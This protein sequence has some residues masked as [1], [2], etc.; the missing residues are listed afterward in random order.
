MVKRSR[1]STQADEE[2]WDPTSSRPKALNKTA[3]PTLKDLSD[4]DSSQ[5]TKRSATPAPRKGGRTRVACDQCSKRRS[6]CSLEGPACEGCVERGDPEGCSYQSL[7]W[8]QN[9]EDLPSRQL[10][11]KLDALEALLRALPK[12]ACPV[13]SP[14][15][16]SPIQLPIPL[17]L[18]SPPSEFATNSVSA[19]LSSCR[20]SLARSLF[21][22]GNLSNMH[23]PEGVNLANLDFELRQIDNNHLL[24]TAR[25]PPVTPTPL[26]SPPQAHLAI[27]FF[28]S[29]V[30]PTFRL[31]YEPIFF[32][33]CQEFWASGMVPSPTWLSLYLAVCASGFKVVLG[34]KEA[35]NQS[36]MME[37][38]VAQFAEKCWS[39]SRDIL[40]GEGFPLSNSL[41]SIQVALTLA[42]STLYGDSSN[43]ARTS[44]LVRLAANAALD[45]GLDVDP[46][47][48]PASATPLEVEMRRRTFW[49]LYTCEAMLELITGTTPSTFAS[50]NPSARRPL[51]L[52]N[53]CYLASGNLSPIGVEATTR[54][55][56]S[57]P[58]SA[59]ITVA[60]LSIRVSRLLT[61]RGTD[62]ETEV[63]QL[64][65]EMDS[66]DGAFHSSQVAET[67]FRATFV[68]LSQA[69]TELNLSNR[70]RDA[71]AARHLDTLLRSAVS[72]TS[73]LSPDLLFF[74]TSLS[75]STALRSC[76]VLYDGQIAFERDR[77][78][79]RNFGIALHSSFRA[80]CLRLPVSRCSSILAHVMAQSRRSSLEATPSLIGSSL[81]T[82]SSENTFPSP[83]MSISVN[84][85]EATFRQPVP[86][87]LSND[88][89]TDQASFLP[90]IGSHVPTKDSEPQDPVPLRPVAPPHRPLLT[91]RTAV[92]PGGGKPATPTFSPWQDT[93]QTPSR[94]IGYAWNQ[95]NLF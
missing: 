69:A 14:P 92:A 29:T 37:D 43:I 26:P 27:C 66:Y 70:E 28:S 36:G 46:R 67:M 85:V 32:R 86:N 17:P 39:E 12:H 64:M 71:T 10:R 19:S 89:F 90:F 81:A 16:Q 60:T 65:D 79:L 49:A 44:S 35:L 62:L 73:N 45:M 53:D 74:S 80:S 20:D 15:K 34:D 3:R 4:S 87:L 25:I 47:D 23:L 61:S 54:P 2:E 48:G 6:R 42:L 1:R 41:D 59:L 75:L 63:V 9:V 50:T 13:A 40:E 84:G 72:P 8:I 55:M 33:E 88:D 22:N 77:P 31:I 21:F 83:A 94:Y 78:D 11:R 24:T 18:A 91:L 5:A 95:P 7:I 82:P 58:T 38:E 76:L 56:V 51:F 30:N 52:S 57:P 68:R 93:S